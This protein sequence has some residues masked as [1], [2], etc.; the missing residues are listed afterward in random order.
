[1]GNQL[2]VPTDELYEYYLT[3]NSVWKTGE[4]FGLA[5][6]TVHERLKRYNKK[7]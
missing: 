3:C 1:M 6:Q 7:L 4:H 2:T 5:G